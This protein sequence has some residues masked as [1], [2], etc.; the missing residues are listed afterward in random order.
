[1]EFT[2][3]KDCLLISENGSLLLSIPKQTREKDLLEYYSE[4]IDKSL[5]KKICQCQTNEI[6]RGLQYFSEYKSGLFSNAN[7]IDIKK[8]SDYVEIEISI[9]FDWEY[10]DKPI[11]VHEFLELYQSEMIDL[12]FD[13][14]IVKE[15]GWASLILCFFS[16]GRPAP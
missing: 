16:K 2:E 11:T 3:E 10:W 1:M 4:N 8:E 6:P 5:S 12:G 9:T 13:T 7:W 14:K 15:E